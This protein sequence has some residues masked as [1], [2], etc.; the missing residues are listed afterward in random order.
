[1]HHG[2]QVKQSEVHGMAKRGG[3]VFSHVRFGSKVWSPVIA[4]G[5]VDILIAL[6]WAEGLR[7]LN[8]L[9]RDGGTFIA[10]TQKI[11][12]PISFRNRQRGARS[13][14]QPETPAEIV[15][16]VGNGFALDATHIAA[17]LGNERA[18]NAVLLGALSTALDFSTDAW[19][20][21]LLQSVPKKTI[22]TNRNAFLAGREWVETA[23]RHRPAREPAVSHAVVEAATH[24]VFRLEITEAWCKSCDICVKMCPERCLA[25]NEAQI[26]VLKDPAAC[27]ACRLCE[28]LCPDFA[29]RV[30][31][32]A[33]PEAVG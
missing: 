19:L 28:W 3:G 4:K 16:M 6:E 32:E 15:D 1:Q 10:D 22:D 26:A 30:V 23:D 25:L 13:G 2:L 8:H 5:E 29:I 11:V 7:W 27:T 14:Y 9:K 24:D 21:V 17:G 33:A 18:A 31:R 12:P 20:D